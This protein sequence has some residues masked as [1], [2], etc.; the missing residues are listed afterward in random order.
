MKMLQS[1]NQKRKTM[2]ITFKLLISMFCLIFIS[3]VLQAQTVDKIL[4]QNIK[5][6]GGKK[7][8]KVET[9]KMIGNLPTPNGGFSYNGLFKKA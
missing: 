2:K 6:T 4:K 3:G 8:K 5:K 1:S 9:I 7:Y